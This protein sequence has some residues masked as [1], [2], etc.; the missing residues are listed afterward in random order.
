MELKHLQSSVTWQ[1]GML[2]FLQQFVYVWI[3][4]WKGSKTWSIHHVWV[5]LDWNPHTVCTYPLEKWKWSILVH[6]GTKILIWYVLI[7]RTENG[8]GSLQ[9]SYHSKEESQAPNSGGTW[10][11]MIFFCV[12]NIKWFGYISNHNLT[13]PHLLKLKPHLDLQGLSSCVIIYEILCGKYQFFF[14]FGVY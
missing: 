2:R 3:L 12:V 10:H 7:I 11:Q 14:M 1:Y 13:G 8:K 4:V 9:S 5:I 6:H